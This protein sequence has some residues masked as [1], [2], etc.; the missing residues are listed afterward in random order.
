MAAPT[1]EGSARHY[2]RLR[3]GVSLVALALTAGYLVA[4]LATDAA[5]R[6]AA[7]AAAWTSRPGLQLAIA[8]AVLA[9]GWRLLTLPLAW[10]GSYW[11]PRR[12]GLLHQSAGH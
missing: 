8:L 1:G 7:I 3:L 2:H 5:G 6:L 9:T 4:L 11:L 12:F 10:I